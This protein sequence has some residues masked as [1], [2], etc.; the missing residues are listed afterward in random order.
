MAA[1]VSR[2]S[3]TTWPKGPAQAT[4]NIT[5][6]PSGQA[7]GLGALSCQPSSNT[8]Y[9]DILVAPVQ[10]KSGASSVSPT[11]TASIYVVV[12]E[13][14]S[15]FDGAINPDSTSDQSANLDYARVVQQIDVVAN[16]TTYAFREFSIWSFLGFI[17]EYVAI[18][19][20]NNSGSAFDTTAASFSAKYTTESFT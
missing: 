8:P 12:S 15:V 16:A 9:N 2:G 18:V 4:D 17:P 5:S 1:P 13:D 6:L 10:I 7:K 3:P 19:V 14:N 20:L 11:G